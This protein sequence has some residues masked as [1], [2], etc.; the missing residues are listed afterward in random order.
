[1]EKNEQ[2]FTRL[3]EKYKSTVYAVCYMFSDSRDELDDLFQEVLVKLWKGYGSFR[4][5]SD[6]RTWIYRVSLNCCL[7]LQKRKKREA[8]HIPLSI[9]IDPFE[10]TSD[11]ALQIRRLYDRIN[12]LGLVDRAL[13]LLWLEGMSYAEIGEIIGISVKNVSFQ[14]YRIKE[15]LKKMTI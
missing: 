9:D 15:E 4:E 2:E 5:E 1:M 3:V 11:R 12:R 7:N 13:I 14:L 10:G 8:G 6:I